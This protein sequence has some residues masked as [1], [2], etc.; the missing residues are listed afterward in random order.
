MYQVC[1][2]DPAQ[3]SASAEYISEHQLATKIAVI[4]NNADAYSTGIYQN[5]AGEAA[6]VGIE[7]VSAT[8]F[9]DDTDGLLRA[10]DRRQGKRR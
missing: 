9:T 3:G 7:I 2:N 4:Y 5:F 1:F 8:T 10:A 6:K